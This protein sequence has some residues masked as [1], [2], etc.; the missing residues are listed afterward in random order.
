[1]SAVRARVESGFGDNISAD[2]ED[3]ER[4]VGKIRRLASVI[5]ELA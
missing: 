4:G 2:A 3:E 1:M 5:I